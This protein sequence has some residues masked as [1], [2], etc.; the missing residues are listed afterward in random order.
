MPMNEAFIRYRNSIVEDIQVAIVELRSIAQ[1]HEI[2]QLR[3]L[4]FDAQDA[5]TNEQLQQI[6]EQVKNLRE[7]C[8][9]RSKSTATFPALT[10]FRGS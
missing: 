4:E 6:A 7:F 2:T 5:K 10:R 1:P 3:E 8:E 9:K